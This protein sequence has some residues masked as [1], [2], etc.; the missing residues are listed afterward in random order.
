[1]EYSEQFRVFRE[2]RKFGREQL[3]EKAGCHRNTVINVETGRPVKFETVAALMEEL[4]YARTSPETKLLALLW[5][6]SVTGI[7]VTLSEARELRRSANVDA[8]RQELD[9]ALASLRPDELEL[10]TFAASHK[11]IVQVLR[12]IRTLVSANASNERR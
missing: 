7:A 5:L 1:M 12:A 9:A 11:E 6:E 3:A 2:A 4:G 8:A 10:I